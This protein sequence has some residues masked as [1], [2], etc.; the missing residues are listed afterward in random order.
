VIAGRVADINIIS[1]GQISVLGAVVAL[2]FLLGACA[3]LCDIERS[4]VGA[5]ALVLGPEGFSKGRSVENVDF[6]RG[7]WLGEQAHRELGAAHH[8]LVRVVFHFRHGLAKL[9]LR[10]GGGIDE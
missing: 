2:G 3:Q 8:H 6:G 5:L 10:C 1:L 7:C 4:Q 9:Q